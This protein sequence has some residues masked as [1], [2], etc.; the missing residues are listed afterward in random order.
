[1]RTH[2][3]PDTQTTRLNLP[4][5]GNLR[6]SAKFVAIYEKV[7]PLVQEHARSGEIYAA[8]DCPEVY[9]LAGYKNPTP[10]LFDFFD[11]PDGR[12]ER[13]LNLIDSRPI[14]VVVLNMDPGFSRMIDDDFYEALAERFPE[15]DTVGHFEV[16]WKR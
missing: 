11:K 14:Q 2:F 7:I 5:A 9:F 16:R 12:A 15:K 13:L 10:T 1:M 4:R 3:Q 8:P 6:V